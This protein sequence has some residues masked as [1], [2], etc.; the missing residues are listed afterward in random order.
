M[1]LLLCGKSIIPVLKNYQLAQAIKG[2]IDLG[3]LRS[4]T[5][6]R[7]A[8]AVLLAAALL[9]GIAC[10]GDDDDDPAAAKPTQA[11]G[12]YPITV[13]DLLGRSVEITERPGAVV[14]LSPTAA[15]FVFAAGGSLVGRA[16]S[17]VYPEEVLT[18]PEIGTAYQPNFEAILAL[19]PDLIVADSVIHAAP[20]FKGPLED[21][22]VTLVFAGADSYQGVLDGLNLMG[23][24][25]AE[26]QNT[27]AVVEAVEQ[28]LADSIATLA[29]IETSAVVLISDR[30]QVLYA[31]K[32]N[33]YAGDL[34]VQLGIE[35]P[36]AEDPDSG[37]FPGY[38]ALAP[39]RLLQFDPDLIVTVS[40][41][42]PPAPRLGDLFVQIPPF[43]SLSAVTDD[44]VVELEADLM[45]QSPG[46]RVIMALRAL[47]D[48]V[49]AP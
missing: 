1:L 34:L 31:A 13:T 23:E 21:L 18:V 47:T 9:T 19:S 25:F 42:P 11:E 4:A 14:A 2:L 46:P 49:V 22:G 3:L 26:S 6:W 15:E 41:A 40:P 20:T 32:N 45:L 48:A 12:N 24:V 5:H 27:D 28:T 29:G 33:S 36:A 37:P 30:D 39:E 7:A 35:N 38:T 10:G 8:V 17:V 44:R 16:S 43:Q